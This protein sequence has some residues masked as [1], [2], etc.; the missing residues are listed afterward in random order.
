MF[1]Q[2]SLEA[3]APTTPWIVHT[4][5]CVRDTWSFFFCA[6]IRVGS[7]TPFCHIRNYNYNYFSWFS[8]Y[9]TLQLLCFWE[10]EIT[11][12][13]TITPETVINYKLQLQLLII[14]ESF[15]HAL[16]IIDLKRSLIRFNMTTKQELDRVHS[17]IKFSYTSRKS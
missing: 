14:D 15:H 10:F 1:L 11:I 2:L 12:T 3:L 8:N 6:C 9:I 13:I 5:T 17:F 7:I 16:S 4:R